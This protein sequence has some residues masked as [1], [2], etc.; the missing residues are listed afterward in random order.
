MALRDR[1]RKAGKVIASDE[2]LY[3]WAALEG[4]RLAPDLEARIAALRSQE[5]QKP[6]EP[7]VSHEASSTTGQANSGG[8]LASEPPETESR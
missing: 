7:A 8:G 5:S 1:E 4:L 2:A 3:A 6:P